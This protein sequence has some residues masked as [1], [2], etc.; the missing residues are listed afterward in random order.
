MIDPAARLVVASSALA[1]LAACTPTVNVATEEPIRI[2]LDVNIT[3]DV[4][5]RLDDDVQ[6]LITENP[7]LF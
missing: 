5:V 2:Q 7:D 1:A 4:R 6:G 3:Q